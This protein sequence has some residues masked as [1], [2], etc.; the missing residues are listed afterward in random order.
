MKPPHVDKLTQIET[1]IAEAVARIDRQ[2]QMIVEFQAQ[3]YDVR[4]PLTLLSCLLVNLRS[5]EDRRRG[6]LNSDVVAF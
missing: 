3:G 5:L 6:E 4:A 1:A 2:R